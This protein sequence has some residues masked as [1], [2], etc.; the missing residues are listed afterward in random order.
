M[1]SVQ[2]PPDLEV[3]KTV[4]CKSRDRADTEASPVLLLAP[5]PSHSTIAEFSRHE[6][7]FRS[8]FL[9]QP[10]LLLLGTHV[11]H[12]RMKIGHSLTQWEL[13]PFLGGGS[14]SL[15]VGHIPACCIDPE[16]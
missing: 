2:P 5:A 15:F 13:G 4:P 3:A 1:I 16:L 14:L 8:F 12:Y 11:I 9:A 10:G 6:Y 7:P